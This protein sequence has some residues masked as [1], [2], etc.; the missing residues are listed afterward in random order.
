MTPTLIKSDARSVYAIHEAGHTIVAL[1]LD[2]PVYG[3]S[4]IPGQTSPLAPNCGRHSLNSKSGNS[5]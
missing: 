5:P 2:L 4:I 3:C 1:L